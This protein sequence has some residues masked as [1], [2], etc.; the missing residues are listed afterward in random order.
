M[1]FLAVLVQCLKS[2]AA[3]V[4]YLSCVQNKQDFFP[5]FPFSLSQHGKS[6]FGI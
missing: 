4:G 1:F 6:T 5:F 2:F 3:V